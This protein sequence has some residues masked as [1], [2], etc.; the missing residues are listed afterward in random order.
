LQIKGK[1]FIVVLTWV[2]LQISC[3]KTCEFWMADSMW[4]DL[5]RLIVDKCA[6]LAGKD[7]WDNNTVHAIKVTATVSNLDVA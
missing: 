3:G 6:N 5:E 1:K 7:T 4:P 2:P